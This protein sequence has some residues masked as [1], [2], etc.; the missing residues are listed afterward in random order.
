MMHS[1]TQSS[2]NMN[3]IDL[4]LWFMIVRHI[5]SNMP[6]LV[7]DRFCNSYLILGEHIVEYESAEVDSSFLV[8]L[9]VLDP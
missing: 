1:M 5:L 4:K 3:P 9:F 7:F 2:R 6:Y 8:C